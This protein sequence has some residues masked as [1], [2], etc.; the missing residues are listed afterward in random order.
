[1]NKINNP[2][3]LK[4]VVLVAVLFLSYE[5]GTF[6]YKNYLVEKELE[7]LAV[8]NVIKKYEPKKYEILLDSAKMYKRRDVSQ[9]Y[10][11]N[12]QKDLINPI[13]IKTMS[14]LHFTADDELVVEYSE[15]LKKLSTNFNE[16]N[17]Y[18]FFYSNDLNKSRYIHGSLKYEYEHLAA[19]FVESYY[20]NKRHQIMSV[21]EYK[22][23]IKE[24]IARAIKES[25]ISLQTFE[26]KYPSKEE[27]KKLC[28]FNELM[29]TFLLDENKVDLLRFTII[30]K[31]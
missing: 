26:N 1:M 4:Y 9:Q 11:E 23:K 12:T 20:K 21:N 27:K 16:E 18:N 28:K 14:N 7:N 13:L 24:Y 29:Y 31:K 8:L 25:K 2:P 5:I 22:D 10:Y 3:S 6:F 17:C 19:K 15:L 30:S